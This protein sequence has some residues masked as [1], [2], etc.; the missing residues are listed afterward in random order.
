VNTKT[1]NFETKEIITSMMSYETRVILLSHQTIE[2]NKYI[3]FF[4]LKIQNKFLINKRLL[5]CINKIEDMSK[6][7]AEQY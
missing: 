2:C 5:E 3:T 6:K 4:S 1:V 7:K